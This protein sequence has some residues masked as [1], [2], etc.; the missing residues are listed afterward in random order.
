M[1]NYNVLLIE[2]GLE[3]ISFALQIYEKISL[4]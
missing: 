4:G 2:V 1:A 3:I